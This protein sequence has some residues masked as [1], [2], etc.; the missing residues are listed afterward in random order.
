MGRNNKTRY[1]PSMG[2]AFVEES[3]MRKLSRLAEDGWLLESFAFLG[4]KLRRGERQKLIYSMDTYDLKPG[5]REQ[6]YEMFEAGGW[7]HVCSHGNIHIFSASPDTKPIYSDR[8][9]LYEKY[10]RAIGLWR[11]LTIIFGLTAILS[12]TLHYISLTNWRDYYLA[13]ILFTAF[14]ASLSFAVP[15]I[16]TYTAFF[17]R[18]RRFK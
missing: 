16:M 9:T 6:Y 5:E 10:R 15:S 11:L 4:Y 17:I 2:L 13:N 8:S 7:K 12:Y 1:M 18:Q 3:E 14:T